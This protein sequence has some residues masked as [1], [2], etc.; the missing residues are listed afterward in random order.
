MLVLRLKVRLQFSLS[1][2]PVS[3]AFVPVCLSS[4]LPF[5]AQLQPIF[6]Y[7]TV[8]PLPP[9]LSFENEGKL[10]LSSLQFFGFTWLEL[11]W[12]YPAEINPLKTRTNANA[13]SAINNWLFKYVLFPPLLFLEMSE[14]D[15]PPFPSPS[16]SFTVV[17]FTPPFLAS[18][19]VGCFAFFGAI[20]LMFLPVIYLFCSFSSSLFCLVLSLTLLPSHR[21]RDCRSFARGYVDFSPFFIDF[22]ADFFESAP[23]EIDIVFARG[24]IEGVSYVKMAAEMPRL[25]GAEI[26][27]EWQRYVV[28][29]AR[30]PPFPGFSPSSL[31][32]PAPFPLLSPSSSLSVTPCRRRRPPTP[33]SPHRSFNLFEPP[34]AFFSSFGL[35]A[36]SLPPA[37]RLGLGELPNPAAAA[38][39]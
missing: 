38:A 27:A 17:M 35:G 36:D 9:P 21:P 39:H 37:H 22:V 26:E 12:L 34:P 11:P 7:L 10:T 15:L 23:P 2:R 31:V 18:S 5:R 1:V 3:P 32:Y 14:I 29:F 20:N 19:A 8:R 13:V 6:L 24:Y 30:F 28:F 16:P 4:S 33:P 25:S